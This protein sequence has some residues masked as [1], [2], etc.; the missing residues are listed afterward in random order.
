M[1][2]LEKFLNFAIGKKYN[3]TASKLFT[4]KVP[5]KNTSDRVSD[6][7]L[8]QEIVNSKGFFCSELVASAYKCLG[9][10]PREIAAS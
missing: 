4:K 9:L 10:L 5:I 2:R 3:F 1:Q 6:I 7:E 8:E